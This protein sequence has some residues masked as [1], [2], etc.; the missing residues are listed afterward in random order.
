MKNAFLFA[1]QGSQFPGMGGE[2]LEKYPAGK[3]IFEIGSEILGYDLYELCQNADAQVLSQTVNSQP[4]IF[5]ISLI[6]LETFKDTGSNP[7]MVAGHSLGEY[8]AMV[9]A[10]ILSVEDGF[11]AIRER[12]RAMEKCASGQEGAMCAVL[13]LT[14]DEVTEVCERVE[15]YVV[16]VN[17]NSPTQ[18]VISGDKLAVEAAMEIFTEMKKRVMK[19]AVSAAF[20]S[21]LMQPAAEEFKQGIQGMKFHAPSC[22]FFSNLT[23]GLI[24]NEWLDDMPSYLATHIVSPVFFTNEL[25]AMQKAGADNFIECGP[26]KVLTGLVK[27]TLK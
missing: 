18:T 20:H 13:G 15:G 25:L 16:P 5:A 11:V 26:G 19:L 12:A 23:G 17:F 2:F 4:A 27:K 7:D 21:K 10:G 24:T 3:H 9:A 6:A 8:A 22:L 14:S 1:G